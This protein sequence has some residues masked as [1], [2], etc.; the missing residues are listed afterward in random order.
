MI[1]LRDPVLS[2]VSGIKSLGQGKLT[3]PSSSLYSN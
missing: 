3:H 1:F 2:A